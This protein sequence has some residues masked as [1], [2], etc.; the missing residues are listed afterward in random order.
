M[1][2]KHTP[3]PWQIHS[4][5]A[6]YCCTIVGDIDGP[7]ESGELVYTTVCDVADNDYFEANARL[8]SSAPDLLEALRDAIDAVKVFHGP[9]A[10]DIYWEHSPECKRW[11]AAI[12]KATGSAS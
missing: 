1:S 12:A 9:E 5:Q 4:D 6:P 7:L 8:I 11:R 10:W 2:A 3:G